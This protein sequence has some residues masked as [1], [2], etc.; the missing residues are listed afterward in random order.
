MAVTYNCKQV[1]QRAL[2]NKSAFDNKTV[3]IKEPYKSITGSQFQS[4]ETF[5]TKREAIEFCRKFS[6]P[7]T[8]LV[9]VHTRF[10]SCWAIGLG[11]FHFV[12]AHA[13]GLIIAHAMGCTVESIIVEH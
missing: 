10:D 2:W 5:R 9:N 12:P 6:L 4:I 3:V 8:H 11:R 13:E 1:G 7:Q